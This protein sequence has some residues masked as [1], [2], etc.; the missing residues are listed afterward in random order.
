MALSISGRFKTCPY[1]LIL[2]HGLE[3]RHQGLPIR[4]QGL[5]P[6]RLSMPVGQGQH[7]ACKDCIFFIYHR[8]QSA[9]NLKYDHITDNSTVKVID[10]FKWNR[11]K[12]ITFSFLL[13]IYTQHTYL[14]PGL[15]KAS[16]LQSLFHKLH[17]SHIH[18]L[19]SF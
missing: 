1:S 10:F 9:P 11:N 18:P 14:S 5:T 16:F 13:P 17:I 6:T 8:F 7:E 2:R 19:Q 15:P 3:G 4:H 12:A